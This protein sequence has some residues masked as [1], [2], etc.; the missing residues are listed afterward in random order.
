MQNLLIAEVGSVHDGSFGNAQK[1][2]EL[3]AKC[4][5]DAV[6]FQTHIAD[7]ESLP[8]APSP[9]YFKNEPRMEYFRRTGFTIDEWRS[10]KDLAE[11]YN[12]LFLSS[13][14]SLK[15]VDLLESIN[16]EMYKIPSGEVTNI[17]LLEK[18]ADLQKP[19]LLSSG[20]S[21]WKELDQA[22]AV[23]DNKCEL[24]VL[25]CT[26]KYPC[27]PEQI[28]LN[29]MQ[30]IQDR[31]GCAVGLSDH[32]LGLAA[33]IAAVALGATVIEKH[34]TFSKYMYGSDASNSMEPDA[35]H[36]LALALEE[37]W[38]MLSNPVEKDSVEQFTEMKNIFQKS[39]VA[40]VDIQVGEV[41]S[42]DHLAYKKPGNGI[43]PSLY[44]E[45]LGKKM[46]VP[47]KKDEMFKEGYWE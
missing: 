4:G 41:L 29:V 34:F 46:R 38:S 47:I 15:A 21:N 25:Q 28:G 5:A 24:T 31:Y 19:V 16:M 42:K 33:P 23:F 14:F 10:L 11:N 36:Q 12:L 2:I 9:E 37:T 1:L 45:M 27:P 40:T 26:S 39:I 35:F 30:Q 13:P 17:P 18:I 20:M 32:S 3:S 44:R 6:K 7:E 8:G 22:V 43:P